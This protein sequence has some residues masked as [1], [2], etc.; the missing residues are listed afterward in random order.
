MG[1][2]IKKLTEWLIA[3]LTK[4]RLSDK[5]ATWIGEFSMLLLMLF[6]AYIVYIIS[7]RVMEKIFIPL[8]KKSKNQFDDLLIKNSFFKKLSF[9]LPVIMM[10]SFTD[11]IVTIPSLITFIR[12]TLEIVF[13][14]NV[15]LILSSIISTIND[16]YARYSF[17]KEYPLN[18]IFQV[19][20][21]VLYI[22]G[23]LV[24]VGILANRNISSLLISLGAL[25]AVGAFVF[26]DPILGLVAGLQLT[27]NKMLAIGD[28][29]S[30][31]SYNADGAVLEI[32]LTTV[33]IQNWDMTITTVPTYSLISQSF[34][35]WRG[36]EDSGGRR[37]KRSIN[38]DMDSISFCT[39]EMLEKYNK[40]SVL[41][42]YLAQ[43]S[44]ELEAYNKKMKVDS[45]SLVNGRRLTNIGVF[46]AYLE[47]YLKGRVDIHH[48]MTFLVRQL[49]P[50]E[51]GLPIEIYVF[52]K[53][54]AWADYE[55]IQSDIFDHILG[56][57]PEFELRTYQ[58][59]K[60]GDFSALLDKT[61]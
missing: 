6:F 49:Q 59:P 48:D 28:W 2:Y 15:I 42:P 4:T 45:S 56:A 38:I 13:V 5:H 26:K 31:P 25:S 34:Q 27:F 60:S 21:I 11:D 3:L 36:M 24:I 19:L 51:K 9:L 1:V 43:K 16:F 53:T 23:G 57:I 30:M 29:I 17:S 54:T 39:D 52:T 12:T 10:Y 35:N 47:A 61:N 7:W 20:N 8:M 55:G 50:Y 37:I 18:A 33:K 32:D 41:V 44:T 14:V 58:L 22:L 40:I 46:R